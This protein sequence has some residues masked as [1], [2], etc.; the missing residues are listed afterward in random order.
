MEKRMKVLIDTV[1]EDASKYFSKENINEFIHEIDKYKSQIY[2]FQVIQ[3]NDKPVFEFGADLGYSLIDISYDGDTFTSALFPYRSIDSIRFIKEKNFSRLQISV[4]IDQNSFY[5]DVAKESKKKQI[6][7]YWH[8][9]V[10]N[11]SGGM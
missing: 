2:F 1:I 8:H 10:T 6:E 4:L 9:I 5:Y 3:R 7:D 11:L